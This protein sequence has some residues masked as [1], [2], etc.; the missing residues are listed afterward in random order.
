MHPIVL[1]DERD[2]DQVRRAIDAGRE[3]LTACIEMGGSLTGEHGIGVEKI[4][5]MPLMFS[6]DDLRVMTELRH[7]FDPTGARTPA[8]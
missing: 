8:K 7:V 5:E 3:I 6:P 4:G 1:Y 2:P